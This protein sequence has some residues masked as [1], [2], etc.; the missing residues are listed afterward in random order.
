[1]SS[2]GDVV[3]VC[4]GE[5]EPVQPWGVALQDQRERM[6]SSMQLLME[7]AVVV[8]KRVET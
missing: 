5:P 8:Q 4:E 1:M 6:D 2:L 7:Q 3:V